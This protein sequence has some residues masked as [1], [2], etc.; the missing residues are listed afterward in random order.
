MSYIE[1]IAVGLCTAALTGVL[2]GLWRVHARTASLPH[3][4]KKLDLVLT[5]TKDL[6]AWHDHRDADGVP[7]WFVR[8]SLETAIAKLTDAVVELNKTGSNHMVITQNL[9]N[10]TDRIA[11]KI[12]R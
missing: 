8:Q 6:H 9:A 5:L 11:E 7:V 1:Q 10:L 2:L 4:E 3:I 12:G